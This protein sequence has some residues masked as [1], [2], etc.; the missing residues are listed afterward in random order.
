[1]RLKRLVAAII[2]ATE[3]TDDDKAK[4]V[5]TLSTISEKTFIELEAIYIHGMY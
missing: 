4:L 5:D 2:E 1:M 3:M